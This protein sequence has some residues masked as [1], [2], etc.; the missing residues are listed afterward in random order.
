M[1]VQQ[2]VD[3]RRDKG[4]FAAATQAGHRQSQMTIHAAIDQRIEFVFKSLH[5][6]PVLPEG[7][8]KMLKNMTWRQEEGN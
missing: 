3:H 5:R 7:I 6:R 4:G 8:N 1:Q 2:L